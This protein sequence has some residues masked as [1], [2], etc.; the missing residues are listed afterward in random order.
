[1]PLT[2]EDLEVRARTETDS[3]LRLWLL[4]SRRF[5]QR[6]ARAELRRRSR[7]VA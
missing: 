3:M 6:V 5:V 2:K 7:A 1:M 4:D